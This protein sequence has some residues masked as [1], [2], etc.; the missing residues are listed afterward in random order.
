MTRRIHGLSEIIDGVEAVFVDQYGVLHDGRAAFPG[1][2]DCLEAIAARGLPVLA[3]TNSGKRAEANAA[4][5]ERL[6]FPRRLFSG[7]LSSGETVW[8]RLADALA[9]G[10]IAPGSRV[11]VLARGGDR[12]AVEGLDLVRAEAGEAADLVV[13]A[14]IEP[15]TR[16]REDYRALLAPLARARVPAI[17]ANPDEVMY[18]GSGRAFGPG[19]VAADYRAAGGPVTMA[20]KPA[21]AFFAAAL[22]AVGGIAPERVLMIGDSPVHDIGGAMAVGLRTLL[23]EAGVQSGLG[24]AAPAPDHVIANLVW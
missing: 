23:V 11:L 12:S 3:L 4:R 8:R 16:S 7:V 2:R 1:A 24:Q 19:V 5:L 13:I 14:G 10:R 20:G 21:R 15:E 22:A 17:C 6:G 9:A 18:A